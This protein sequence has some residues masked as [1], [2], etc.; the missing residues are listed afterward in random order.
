MKNKNY[1]ELL[2]IAKS[3]NVIKLEIAYEVH[4]CLNN[5]ITDE[6]FESVCEHV[7][8]AYMSMD[9]YDINKIA[10]IIIDS[11]YNEDYHNFLIN[12][13]GNDLEEYVRV[14][15]YESEAY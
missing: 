11:R 5:D 10:R 9:T 15:F 8:N 12:N 4:C 6:E 2:N 13:F 3:I 14:M 1:T 7:Y